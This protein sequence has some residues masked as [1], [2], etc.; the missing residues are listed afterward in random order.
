MVPPAAMTLVLCRYRYGLQHSFE[1]EEGQEVVSVLCA[2]YLLAKV[3]MA[4]ASAVVGRLPAA[5]APVSR[6][7][8]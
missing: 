2:W 3:M 4:R 7:D 8:P 5:G 1:S 6:L